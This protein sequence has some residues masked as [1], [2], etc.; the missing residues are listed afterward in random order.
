MRAPYI[1]TPPKMEPFLPFFHCKNSKST[2][3]N[4][5]S[6]YLDKYLLGPK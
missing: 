3:E 4:T 2:I 6:K 1:I 5:T